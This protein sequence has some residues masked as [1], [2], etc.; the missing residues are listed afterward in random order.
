MPP[1][2][3]MCGVAQ[4]L[5][6][7]DSF[8]RWPGD[9]LRYC[10]R[11]QH[12]RVSK[13]I[14]EGEIEWSI[15][16]L[17]STFEL[18]FER[19]D[20]E[21]DSHI[22]YTVDNLGGPGGTLADAFLVPCGVRKNDDFRSRVRVDALDSFDAEDRTAIAMAF[23]LGEV[24]LHEGLHVMG[25]GHI[26]TRGVVALLNPQYNPR[27]SGLQP[28]DI[29]AMTGIGYKLRQT[30]APKPPATPGESLGPIGTRMLRAGQT[31]TAK[32]RA[33]LLEEL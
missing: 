20:K 21:S 25:L 7:G 30:P 11:D 3:K 27:I 13:E 18:D 16:F 9:K 8:C 26:E 32:K 22:V 15:N 14:W 23:D 29:K 33:W 19:V 17:E 28:A 2:V 24:I 5:G 31:Y 1:R 6:R 12:P 10:I 4:A